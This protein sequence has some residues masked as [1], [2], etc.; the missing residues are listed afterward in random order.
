M[1]DASTT[2]GDGGAS[3]SENVA[4]LEDKVSD[5]LAEMKVELTAQGEK[6]DAAEADKRIN[7]PEEVIAA[8]QQPR[9]TI[10]E[11]D[12]ILGGKK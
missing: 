12:R 5:V 3:L 7:S 2:M 1:K 11:I 9:D 4:K 10:A 8:T 6:W